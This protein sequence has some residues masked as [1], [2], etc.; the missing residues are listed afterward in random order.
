MT[1]TVVVFRT[2]SDV[3]AWIVRGLLD[4]HGLQTFL[5]SSVTRALFPVSVG[6]LGE[7][8]ISV[9]A[10]QADE[11]RDLIAAQ[12]GGG[13]SSE[14][15]RVLPFPGEAVQTSR[16]E[17]AIGYRFRDP[18]LLAQALTHRSRAQEDGAASV[19]DNESLEFLG[20]A[21]LGF[22]VAEWL[23]AEFPA[24]DE[25][26]KSKIKSSLVSRAS[27]ARIAARLGIGDALLLGR[28]EEKTG[29]RHKQ[30]LLADACEALIA[31]VHLDG[32][33]DAARAFVL[34]ELQPV[35]DL[36]RQPGLLTALTGDYKSALQEVLQARQVPPPDYR[37]L[38]ES[39]PDHAKRFEIE[40]VVE[41]RGLARADGHS[42]KQAEQTAARL[43]LRA[44]GVTETS[45]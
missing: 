28:G 16:L 39:G 41:G 2:H 25:G 33:I 27:L 15:G 40:V 3:E 8:R 43:A 9:P 5:G 14:T 12:R 45:G 29:G 22:V 11:A 44:L 42:K 23:H 24:A 21:I 6:H 13:R 1:D 32:G 20:D 7:V 30:A 38:G 36:A 35:L 4:A 34:R 18:A 37:L 19:G 10:D 26:R 31:A 17:A